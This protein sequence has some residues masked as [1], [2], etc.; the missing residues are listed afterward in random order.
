MSDAILAEPAPLVH[1]SPTNS[2]SSWAYSPDLKTAPKKKVLPLVEIN[3]N[4]HLSHMEQRWTEGVLQTK[5]SV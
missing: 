1:F 5:R 4:H 2:G 3:I